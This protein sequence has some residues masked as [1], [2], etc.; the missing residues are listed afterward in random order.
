MSKRFHFLKIP[1]GLLSILVLFLCLSNSCKTAQTKQTLTGDLYFSFFSFASYY[2]QPDSIVDKVKMYFDTLDIK[3]AS[4]EDKRFVEM[5][6][7]LSDNK[8]IYK[9]YVNI[10]IEP[11]SIVK[12]YLDKGDY[13]KIKIHKR[14]DLQNNNKKIEI[15]ASVT[16]YS[17][18]IY[19][20]DSLMDVQK[21]D[22]KTLQFQK[23]FRIEDYE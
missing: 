7:I 2:N 13:D 5:Y 11:D 3:T 6:R 15:S 23:K 22:G 14:Q 19:F 20:C 21:I 17:K 18:G 4:E 9:P 16:N 12:L 1:F 10:L 8:L